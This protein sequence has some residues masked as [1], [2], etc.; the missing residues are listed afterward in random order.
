MSI[1]HKFRQTIFND[2][3]QTNNAILDITPYKP[4]VIIIGTFNPNTPN[5]NFADFFYGRNFFWPAFKNLF[6]HNN[7][8]LQK[9]RMPT[10]GT[11]PNTLNPTLEEIFLICKKIKVSFA[12][13]VIEI[14]HNNNPKYNILSND[15]II[16]DGQQYNL[17]QDKRKG[18]VYGIEELDTI[19]QIK[20]NTDNIIKYLCQNPQIKSIYFT[21]KPNEIWKREWNVLMNHECTK[22]RTFTNI[23][24]PSGAGI[25]V[26][27]T[28][29]KLLNHWVHNTNANFGKLNNLWLENNGVTLNNF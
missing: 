8:T 27:Y 19:K 13:L 4:E 24:T 7:I 14:L 12:D 5:D 25:P 9:R 23:F 21:R 2:Q 6:T 17:I 10:R 3:F 1:S 15:N 20:W 29:T 26:N 22:N 11:P 18:D 28:M 16:L